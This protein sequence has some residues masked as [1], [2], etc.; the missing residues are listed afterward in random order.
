MNRLLLPTSQRHILKTLPIRLIRL[1][2]QL[3]VFWFWKLITYFH[4]HELIGSPVKLVNHLCQTW[5]RF[6]RQSCYAQLGTGAGNCGIR[7]HQ[8]WADTRFSLPWE[9]TTSIG[10]L[11]KRSK[12]RRFWSKVVAFLNRDSEAKERRLA[13]GLDRSDGK[14][15]LVPIRSSS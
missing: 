14:V 10:Q 2:F 9:A 1:N 5:H 4:S 15:T 13:A 3:F 8:L 6:H 12:W 7:L 11:N